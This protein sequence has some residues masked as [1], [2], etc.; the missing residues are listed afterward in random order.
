[1]TTTPNDPDNAAQPIPPESVADAPGEAVAGEAGQPDQLETIRRES[2]ENYNRYLRAVADLDTFRRRAA[3]EKE[4]L[5]Q[6]AAKDLI[7]E[8]MPV[9]DNLSLGLASAHG[10]TDPKAIADGVSMVLEQLKATLAKHG[11][12]EIRP[13][14]G[15]DFDPHQHE[16]LSHLPDA[17]IPADK[18]LQMVRVGYSLRSRLLRPASVVLS[19][20]PQ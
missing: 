10:A 2:A 5:R 14:P 3:R 20:G 17:K 8:L 6:L 16:S 12:I 11:L 9:V 1:M 7:E 19:R 18:V 15:D 4:E 13:N